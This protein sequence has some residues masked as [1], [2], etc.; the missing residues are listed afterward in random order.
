MS[1]EDERLAENKKILLNHKG[2][3]NA[4]TAST[5]GKA[6]DIPE[7]DTVA[8]TRGLITKLIKDERLPIGA[9]ET[10]YFLVENEEELNEYTRDLNDRIYGI[11]ERINRLISNFNEYY[12]KSAKYVG[13]LGEGESA[14]L[15]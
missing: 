4:I 9:T 15:V 5:I 6:L 2:K 1:L 11:Y 10:G 3:A 13:D 14:D 12:G 8:T 7:N